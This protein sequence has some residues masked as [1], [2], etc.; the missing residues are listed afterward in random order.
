[1][2]HI[3]QVWLSEIAPLDDVPNAAIGENIVSRESKIRD[4]LIEPLGLSSGL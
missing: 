4:Q 2:K 1:M 3:A